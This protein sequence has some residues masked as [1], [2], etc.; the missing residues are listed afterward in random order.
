MPSNYSSNKI[1]FHSKSKGI[2]NI[3]FTIFL[4]D[5]KKT[6]ILDLDETLI[7]SGS[8]NENYDYIV[9][10]SIPEG[11]RKVFFQKKSFFILYISLV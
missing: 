8:P 1:F 10:F 5:S 11:T 4:L 6:L 2:F 3:N 9:K 7:K